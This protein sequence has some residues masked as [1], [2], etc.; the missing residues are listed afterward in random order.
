[1]STAAEI[2]AI[3]DHAFT[4]PVEHPGAKARRDVLKA[5]GLCINAAL[6]PEYR[7]IRCRPS[8]MQHGAPVSPSGKCQRCVDIHKGKRP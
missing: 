4:A 5:L 1:M 6:P 2:Q 3:I 7:R 8:T